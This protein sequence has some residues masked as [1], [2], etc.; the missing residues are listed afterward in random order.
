MV[1]VNPYFPWSIP[2]LHGLIPFYSHQ[3][4]KVS[5]FFLVTSPIF[6]GK[7]WGTPHGQRHATPCATVHAQKERMLLR[8]FSG[9]DQP[10][11]EL[12]EEHR[13]LTDPVS[14]L[15]PLLGINDGINDG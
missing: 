10:I 15:N 5:P 13:T 7:S 9:D 8:I 12:P 1:T 4:S 11:Q 2:V 14:P 6:P 3:I